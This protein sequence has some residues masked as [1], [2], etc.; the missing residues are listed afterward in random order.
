MSFV[1]DNIT[2]HPG[3]VPS[4]ATLRVSY[5]ARSFN[6]NSQIDVTYTAPGGMTLDGHATSSFHHGIATSNTPLQDSFVV[7]AAPGNYTIS[8]H[9]DEHSTGDT[10]DESVVINVT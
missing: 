9:A 10:D 2:P 8:M 3:D 5:T 7:S 1:I 4:G 6:G